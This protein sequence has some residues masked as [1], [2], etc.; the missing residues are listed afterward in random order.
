M[1]S[2]IIASVLVAAAALP[3]GCERQEL[4]GPPD[5]RLARDQC[6]EC[7]MI[8]S[9]ERFSCALLVARDSRREHIIFDDIGCMLDFEQRHLD[10]AAVIDRFTRE[11]VAKEWVPASAATF[12][13]CDARIVPTPM[14][15]GVLVF[16]SPAAAKELQ[17]RLS[18][19]LM[20]FSQLARAWLERGGSHSRVPR[21]GK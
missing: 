9:D 12:L 21:E 10:G 7:G 6:A 8:I 17:E 16:Q 5:I 4:V 15:S 13:A 2:S 1:K 20:D 19:D 18:G 11:Y 14:G 3:A